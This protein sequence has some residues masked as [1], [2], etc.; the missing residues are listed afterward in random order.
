MRKYQKFKAEKRIK[1]SKILED[2]FQKHEFFEME[3]F[4]VTDSLKK[5]TQFLYLI[6]KGRSL[7]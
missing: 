2:K 3:L 4:D 5:M 1:T 7:E 6:I